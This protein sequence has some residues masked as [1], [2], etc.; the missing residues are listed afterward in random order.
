MQGPVSTVKG[1]GLHIGAAV[2]SAVSV[3]PEIQCLP[4]SL[5]AMRACTSV[6]G[7]SRDKSL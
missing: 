5:E 3:P 1:S 2:T 4:R 6:R 7:L